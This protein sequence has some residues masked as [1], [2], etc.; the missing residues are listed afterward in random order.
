VGVSVVRM[1]FPLEAHEALTAERRLTEEEVKR[2]DQSVQAAKEAAALAL[3]SAEKAEAKHNELI[4]KGENERAEFATKSEVQGL[5]KEI[6]S[7]REAQAKIA[8]ASVIGSVVLAILINLILRLSG[9]G[10]S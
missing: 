6:G 3:T 2:V 1:E 7:V 9:I 8:G 10:S 5:Q 4:R